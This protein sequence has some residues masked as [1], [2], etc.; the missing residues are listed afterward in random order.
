MV[1]A[2]LKVN[3]LVMYRGFHLQK[4]RGFTDIHLQI[5]GVSLSYRKEER[6]GGNES[7]TY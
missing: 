4:F 6:G 5:N 7:P 3:S 2:P 1:F